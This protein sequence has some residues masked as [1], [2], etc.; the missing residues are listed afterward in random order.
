[1]GLGI[2]NNNKIGGYQ[3]G[4]KE[5]FAQGSVFLL[6]LLSSQ[7][8]EAIPLLSVFPIPHAQ[9]TLMNEHIYTST[10]YVPIHDSSYSFI[11][12]TEDNVSTSLVLIM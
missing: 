8:R 9:H 11:F 7:Q 10:Q 12:A 1:M 4:K 2:F 5:I 6:G 3:E